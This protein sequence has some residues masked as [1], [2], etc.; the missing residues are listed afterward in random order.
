MSVD[1]ASNNTTACELLVSDCKNDLLLGGE[2]LHV[3]CCA[4]ILN[5]LVQDGMSIIHSAIHKIR[6]LLKHIDCSPA[7]LQ[8]FNSIAKGKGMVSKKG[9]YLDVPT[10][11]NSTYKMIVEASEYKAVL[12]TYASKH[13]EDGPSEYEWEKADAICEFLK[14]FEELTLAVSAH[15]EP[16]AHMFLPLVLSILHALKQDKALQTNDILKELAACMCSK[17]EKYW[18]PDEGSL[19]SKGNPLRKNKEIAFNTALV[20]ATILDP[21]RKVL[22]LEFFYQRVCRNVDQIGIHVNSALVWMRKY[23]ME[24]EQHYQRTS[25]INTGA[26][27]SDISIMGSPA[28]GK[29]KLEAEFEQYKSQVRVA[30][31][32]KSELDVYLEEESEKHVKGF[33]VLAWWN[34][35]S[36]KFP[37]LSAMARDFLAIPLSTVSSESA[38]SLGKRIL[39]DHRSSLTPEMLEALVCTKDWLYKPKESE[40]MSA[41][42]W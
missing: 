19:R 18:E 37:A 10:R 38:F 31:S 14:A 27:F 17:F 4:H 22:Y 6:E 13:M 21:R 34:S 25:T 28:L 16:T 7:R 5:I 26:H 39:G 30:Q 11:W 42:L 32:Q 35:K 24:Y 36:Q 33:D 9:V 12:N 2:H 8:V 20:I 29:R 3:R 1:N 41:I 23:F 15:R 40:G